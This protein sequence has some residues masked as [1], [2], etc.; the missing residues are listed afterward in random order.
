MNTPIL[1]H[2]KV[3]LIVGVANADSIAAGCAKAIS[4]VGAKL[5]L[6][7]RDQISLP[8]AEAVAEM[9]NA[10]LLATMDVRNDAEVD[11]LFERV[12]S[13][14]QKLDFL[15]H[16]IA[17]CGKDDLHGRVVDST[18]DGFAEAMDISCHSFV[19]LARKAE[20]LM[21]EGGAL[22]TMSF[23]GAEKVV[24]NY[25][26]M[27]PVKAALEA[28]V[29]YMAA[30]LGPKDIRVNALS[31]GPM[32]TRAASGLENINDLIADAEQRSP[33][34]RLATSEEVG[35]YACFLVSDKARSVTGS[36]AYIDGGYNIMGGAVHA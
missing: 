2:G 13:R 36:V 31:P 25:G 14:F 5:V 23:F 28:S 17:F 20:P 21:K 6:T 7:C 15:I 18:R 24:G 1:L 12:Q 34:Q 4:A 30:E 33:M 19:R 32:W 8:Y 29:R 11:R 22:L 10:D 26:L 35:A 27:G 16:S 9:S 3:G